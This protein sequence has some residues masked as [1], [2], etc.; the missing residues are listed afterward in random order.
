MRQSA[1]YIIA[2]AEAFLL[3]CL[4]AYLKLDPNVSNDSGGRE[5]QL[6]FFVIVPLVIVALV[7]VIYR[8]CSWRIVRGLATLTLV[9]PP[10]ALSYLWLAGGGPDASQAEFNSG[11]GIFA[12]GPPTALAEAIARADAGQVAALGRKV[13]INQPGKFGYTFLTYAF[14][15]STVDNA[16]VAALLKAGA[17]PNLGNSH[18]LTDTVFANDAVRL[19]MLLDA[20]A[21][22]NPRNAKGEADLFYMT[23]NPEMLRI[24]LRRGA[25]VDTVDDKGWTVL[26]TAARDGR[27][28]AAEVLLDAGVDPKHRAKDGT[29]LAD[30]LALFTA[31][32]QQVERP[33]PARI[34]AAARL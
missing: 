21:D 33:I 2:A 7:T 29:T 31:S 20:G 32:G 30:I 14:V 9:V 15:Q 5:M 25:K 18:P 11:R 3:L 13:A 26:M 10:I 22:P 19:N 1:F 16:V 12:E 6:F 17:D 4:F 27:W 23:E 34:V 8:F 24:L 28:P